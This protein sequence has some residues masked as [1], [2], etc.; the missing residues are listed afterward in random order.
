[1]TTTELSKIIYPAASLY[2]PP[3]PPGQYIHGF[4]EE[5]AGTAGPTGSSTGEKTVKERPARKKAGQSDDI[6]AYLP[7]ITN[8]TYQCAMSFRPDS[9]A[10]LRQVSQQCSLKYENR[11]FIIDGLPAASAGLEKHC[12]DPCIEDVSLP[13]LMV[14]YGVLLQKSSVCPKPSGT[15]GEAVIYYPDIAGKLKKANTNA[16]DK[17]HIFMELERFK[18]IVGILDGS[19]P[20][21][22]I[23]PVLDRY[24]Y[25]AI[26]NTIYFSSPYMAKVIQR[27]RES[28]IRK[29]RKGET[30]LKKNGKP[31]MLPA[32]SYLVDA[33]IA[34]ERNR[35]AVEVV[36]ILVALIEQ[37]GKNIPHI[38]V[39]TIIN[40]TCLLE[41]SLRGQ[42]TG[43]RNN[44]LRRTFS[45]AW[46]LLRSK[47]S[48]CST[49][50]DIQLPDPEDPE[51]IPTCSTLDRV[52][53]FPHAGKGK[54]A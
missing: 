21:A 42:S 35:K 48:L 15:K 16:R 23:L 53:S 49:Y 6:P 46:E 52:F 44:M 43:N 36:L 47:T 33:S 34:K 37:T 30:L 4:R 28:S 26:T 41:R 10:C 12:T 22:S 17:N 19:T 39:K 11:I 38:R 32:Y 5:A 29:N 2:T 3:E 9:H 50:K 7:V 13:L 27:I 31:Q 45:K 25:D 54:D 20:A 18:R 40:K 8:Q 1:M 51:C 14:L 24:T